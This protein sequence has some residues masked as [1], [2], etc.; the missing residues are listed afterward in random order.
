MDFASY[1][2]YLIP[3]KEWRKIMPTDSLLE[4]NGDFCVI[5]RID[6]EPAKC[7]NSDLGDENAFLTKEA[8]KT[9]QIANMSTSILC[10]L[11]DI[12]DIRFVQKGEAQADWNGGDVDAKSLVENFCSEQPSPWFEVIWYARQIHAKTVP[13]KKGVQKQKEFD[14]IKELA[15]KVRSIVL[16]TLEEYN[17]TENPLYGVTNLS[18]CP[19]NTNY[20][21][22]TLDTFSALSDKPLIDK[23]SASD[24][25]LLEHVGEKLLRYTYRR[26]GDGGGIPIIIE[27]NWI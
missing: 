8:L 11:F 22:F 15:F 7:I 6:G 12:K 5:R 9:H 23:L 25:R 26:Y 21:H 1:P 17:A 2:N 13:Y 14:E 3:R 19:T 10:A 16:N 20:W 18:H 4:S 27:K 24:K